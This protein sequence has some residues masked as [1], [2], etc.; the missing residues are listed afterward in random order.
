MLVI[1]TS[2]AIASVAADPRNDPL[3]ERLSADGDLHAPHLIDVEVTNA[4]RQL[5]QRGDL[6]AARADEARAA[7]AEL[8]IVRYPHVQLW[9]RMW[10]LRG[11]LTAYDAAFVALAELLDVAL[12]TIDGRLARAGVHGATVELY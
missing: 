6:D 9:D 7:F 8:T 3:V 10:E 5:V 2:A 12:I 11:N 1:D 4:L